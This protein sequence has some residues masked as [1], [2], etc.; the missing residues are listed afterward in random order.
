MGHP[1]I[2]IVHTVLGLCNL[3]SSQSSISHFCNSCPFVKSHRLPFA[4][5]Q[6]R[7]H[8]PFELIHIDLWGPS[9]VKSITGSYYFMLFIDNHTQ[10]TR[11]YF[12]TT[13][14]KA[15]ALFVKFYTM[16]QA[17]FHSKIMKVQSGWCGEYRSTSKLFDSLGILHQI[18]CPYTPQQNGRVER[19]NRH[20]VEVGL[21]LLVQSSMPLIYRSYAFQTT[22]YLINRLHTLLLHHQSP[23][24]HLY[25]KSPTYSHLKTFGC[26]CFPFLRPYNN[27]KL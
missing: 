3:H 25:S 17:Q 23:Y 2:P 20:V 15:Y 24:H 13:K 6:S 5:S 9:L 22:T 12:L 21:S 26:A 10:F 8:K 14:D 16:I 27:N 1:V 4:L 19:I 7:A 18:S 11:I